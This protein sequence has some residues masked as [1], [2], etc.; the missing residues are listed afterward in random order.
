MARVPGH[1]VSDRPRTLPQ[2]GFISSHNMQDETGAT[3]MPRHPRGDKAMTGDLLYNYDHAKWV[4]IT[5]VEISY[6]GSHVYY[7]LLTDPYLTVDRQYLN[8]IANGYADPCNPICKEG[9]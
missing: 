6:G 9:P 2:S 3:A 8:F 7:D 5:R 4:P 1:F